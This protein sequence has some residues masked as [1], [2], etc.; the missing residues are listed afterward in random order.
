MQLLKDVLKEITPPAG[1]RAEAEL[2]VR[3]LNKRLQKENILATA[4]LGGSTAKGTHLKGDHDVDIFVRFNRN[5]Y[6]DK[7]ISLLVAT[8]LPEA[9]RIHG[10]R[11]YYQFTKGKLAVEVVPVLAIDDP[12]QAQNTTDVSPLHVAY[13]TKKLRGTT[14]ADDIRLTKQF[15]KAIKVYGAESYINGF[16]GHVVDILVLHHHGFLKLLEAACNWGDM[17][18]LDPEAHHEDA[19]FVMDPSKITGP[20]LLVDPVQPE[21]NAAAALSHEQFA[22]FKEAAEAFLERPLKKYFQVKRLTITRIQQEHQKRM[23]HTQLLILESIPLSGTKDVA[24]TKLW[25]LHQHIKHQFEKTGF[26]LLDNGF[27]FVDKGIHYFVLEK[28]RLQKYEERRGPP[29]TATK[30]AAR[31]RKKHKAYERNGRLYARVI[32]K[33]RTAIQLTTS[34]L[35][36]PYVQQRCKQIVRKV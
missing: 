20:M 17:V 1:L 6:V 28:T 30:D 36:S 5:A 16:S 2:I 26:P 13:V 24:G 31:F 35:R 9:T 34:L 10:S 22:T 11:D 23:P 12:V 3:D 15:C 25:K 18:V 7:D 8:I 27:E 4:M 32:R 29:V 21:R 33:Y 19:T 14:L